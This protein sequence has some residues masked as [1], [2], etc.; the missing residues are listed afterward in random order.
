MVTAKIEALSHEGRGIAHVDGKITFVFGALPG[1]T[2]E[3]RY[4]ALHRQYDE[5]SAVN[6]LEKSVDRVVPQCAHFG[7]CG[8]CSLQHMSVEAQRAHKQAIL[9]EHF[10]HQANVAPKEILEP[11]FDQAWEYRRRARLSI[12][13]VEK[14]GAVLVGFHER[15]ARYVAQISQCE[16]LH[17]SIGRKIK[18]LSELLM[19][20]EMK[21]QIAQCEVA[22]GD[23]TSAIILRNLVELPHSDLE[24][25]IGF[26]RD[27]HLHLY[28]QPKN[29]E[30]IYPVYPENPDALFYEIPA[31]QIK[32]FFKPAQ[33][34][35]INQ[36]VNLKMLARA[37]ALLDLQKT[38]H[39]L[40]LFCGIGNF[41]LPIAK[42]CE[43][44]IGVEGSD[45]SILQA[46]KNALENNIHNAEFY[47]Q[48]L[49]ADF[50]AQ[51]WCQRTY[52]KVLLDPPRTG[53]KELIPYFS[54]WK[55][56]VIVYI[57]CNSI[58]LA[59]DTQLLLQLG[60]TLEKAGIM[61][62]FPH[63]EHVEAIAVFL[64]G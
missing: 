56:K 28:L 34:T 51:T 13:Y 36:G 24:K 9:L 63:T 52:D 11:L 10:A 46:Q 58:T 55:P 57:S 7:V 1:E 14:K 6:V 50:S 53:A 41:S 3:F 42:F 62:M 26:A 40:D 22:I 35:Q 44:I 27:N 30:S 4:N 21:A 20:C 38:D 54:L 37:L 31:Q 29:A 47:T 15:G 33:F 17:P 61:D 2:V 16:I 23:N 8:G 64:R 5:G 32:M 60:Y 39:V 18:A 12:K 49:S 45:S 59:R 19:Q 43:K 25:L 48:D